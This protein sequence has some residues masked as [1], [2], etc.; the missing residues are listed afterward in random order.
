MVQDGWRVGATHVNEGE[1]GEIRLLG[2]GCCVDEDEADEARGGSGSR[3]Q[4]VCI[5]T[6][7]NCAYPWS[8]SNTIMCIP[9]QIGPGVS[10]AQQCWVSWLPCSSSPSLPAIQ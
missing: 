5:C 1:G 3:V 7:F 9:P 10:T 6:Y 2:L 4:L 8:T